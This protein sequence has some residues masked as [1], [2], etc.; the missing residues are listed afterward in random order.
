MTKPGRSPSASLSTNQPCQPDDRLAGF[1]S[2]NVAA[3]IIFVAVTSMKNKEKQ[4]LYALEGANTYRPT[5]H[6][7]SPWSETMQHGGPVMGLFGREI[8]KAAVQTDMHVARL[9]MDLFKAVPMATLVAETQFERLGK[10]IAAITSTLRPVNGEAPVARASGLLLRTRQYDSPYRGNSE[11]PLPCATR[12]TARGKENSKPP[13]FFHE[14]LDTRPGVDD[15]R[16]YVW[17]RM[18]LGLVAGEPTSPFQMAVAMMDMTLGSG[19]RMEAARKKALALGDHAIPA[20]SINVDST[21]YW[22]RPFTGEWL[23]MRPS[24]ISQKDGITTVSNIL[25]SKSGRVGTAMA[26]GLIQTI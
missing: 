5:P 16:R 9:T 23:G 15:T 17:M 7:R 4:F 12:E 6:A 25:Y 1:F 10:R 26:S 13:I 22:E 19:L 18:E 14:R 24:V 3:G 11:Y 2:G 20:L 8:E 21:S